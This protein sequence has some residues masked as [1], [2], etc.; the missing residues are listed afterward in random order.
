LDLSDDTSIEKA[1]GAIRELYPDGLDLLVNNAGMFPEDAGAFPPEQVRRAFQ[2]NALGPLQFSLLL[3][4]LL[5]KRRGVVVNVS[6]GM[7]ALHDMGPGHPA[8]RISKTA[9]NAVTRYLSQEWLA[10]GVRVNS[11]CPGWVRTDMGGPG[12]NR[13]VEEGV[14]S[15]LWAAHVPA[16]GP[17]GGFFR[18]GKR[19]DW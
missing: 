16:D 8:Y 5:A 7:G 1:A 12:A 10:S 4:P 15:I 2:T 19:L 3:G 9:L 6:S 11:V 14:N 17:T 18:D 13:S